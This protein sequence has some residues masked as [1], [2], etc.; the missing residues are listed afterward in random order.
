MLL[1]VEYRVP[2]FISS[3]YEDLVEY[4]QKVKESLDRLQV[5]TYWMEYFGARPGSSKTACLDTVAKCRIVVLIVGMRYGSIDEKTGMS[6]THMEYAEA[7]KLNIP[8][9]VYLM[10]EKKARIA[11]IFVDKDEKAKK[12]EEFKAHLLGK[13]QCC[14]FEN[15]DQLANYVMH[16]V[17]P[18]RDKIRKEK[19]MEVNLIKI[20]KSNIMGPARLAE[21]ARFDPVEFN[22]FMIN[23]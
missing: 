9:L 16:G 23:M 10:D 7:M 20:E 12:L 14:F 3:T 15:P 17:L 19:L 18:L 2:V 11:P 5:N 8:V 13:H 6:Y 21:A 4:R 22:D 1:D